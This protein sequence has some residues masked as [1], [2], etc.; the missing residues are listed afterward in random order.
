MKG[1]KTFKFGAAQLELEL[2][3]NLYAVKIDPISQNKIDRQFYKRIGNYN[4]YQDKISESAF[5]LSPVFNIINE[6]TL[7][8]PTGDFYIEFKTSTSRDAIEIILNQHQLGIIEEVYPKAFLVKSED[9]DILKLTNKL[10][11]DVPQ[12]QV[13]EPDLVADIAQYEFE[14]PSDELLAR[15]WYLE[16]TGIDPSGKGQDWKY[17]KGADA[18]VFEAWEILQAKKGFISSPDITIAVLDKGFDLSHPDFEG[19]IIAPRD[20]NYENS[21]LIPK[22]FAVQK[23]EVDSEGRISTEADH[24]T[25]CAGI[26]LAAANGQGVVGVAP[27]SKFMPI[28]Y[29]VANGRFMRAMFRHMIAN[30]AD[31]A[32]CSF[33]N[34]GLPMDRL[35]IKVL[36]EATINGRNGRGMVV[37][38]ATGNAYNALKNNEIATHPDIIAVGATT[39]E[40]TFAPYTNRTNNMSIVAP[41]GYGHSGTMTTTDVGFLDN[42]N[43]NGELVGAGKGKD[44][45]PYYRHN[46]EGTSF[47][48]PVIAGVAAL[49]LSANPNLSASEVKSIMETTAD[50]VGDAGDYDENGHSP[51]FGFGRVNAANAV[52]KALGMPLKSYKTEPGF[53]GDIKPFSFDYGELTAGTHDINSEETFVKV[54]VDAANAGR[55]MLAEIEVALDHNPDNEF[56]LY[57]QKGKKPVHFP[58]DYIDKK[59]GERPSL[60][61]AKVEAGDYYFMLRSINKKSWDYIKG[62][63]DFELTITYGDGNFA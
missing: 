18:K 29:Y 55:D 50:K 41:G 32:S 42:L 15:Q 26:A 56:E 3:P 63:G 2:H 17:R 22:P 48:C 20:F 6:K 51:K 43:E 1:N 52:R 19:K 44:D 58:D 59:L 10:Q 49:V 30:G 5:P 53:M 25:S 11:N 46:A 28:R 16:N 23:S 38:F 60:I 37:V 39:S 8:V 14:L 36:H 31:V 34:I 57:V 13:A 40:D 54:T 7:V 9:A 21:S 12:I 24:G 61:V 35:T 4:I 47:A 33:G 62:G 27:N 45:N